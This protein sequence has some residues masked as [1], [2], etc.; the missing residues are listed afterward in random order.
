[1]VAP[2]S[3]TTLA[4]EASTGALQVLVVDD[5]PVA[6]GLL[7]DMA[8]ACGW[9]VETSPSG[10][11]ALA[12]HRARNLAGEPPFQVLLMDWEM[13]ELDGWDTIAC[14]RELDPT[15]K[16]P[17]TVMVTAHGRDKL[18]QRSSRDQTSLHAFLVKP[19]TAY[20]LS[21]AVSKAQLGQSNVRARPRAMHVDGAR[22]RGLR[23]LLVEDN[24][25]NQ[26]VALELLEGEGAT[27]A[28]ADNGQLG[29]D[30]V[31]D[32][33]PPY[34]AVLM[35]VQMPV[36]DGYTATHVIREDL[37]LVSLPIIAMTANAMAS[38]REACLAAG[39]TDHIG[40]PFDLPYLIQVLRKHTGLD[41][42]ELG[43]STIVSPTKEPLPS[44]DAL[45][46]AGAVARMGGNL[47]LYLRSVQPYIADLTRLPDQLDACLQAGNMTDATRL[48]HTL[49]GLSATVGA[50]AMAMVAATGEKLIQSNGTPDD[51]SAFG[52]AFRTAVNE[53]STELTDMVQQLSARTQDVQASSTPVNGNAL[54]MLT[55]LQALSERL[56]VLDMDAMVLYAE[57]RQKY[58]TAN[59]AGFDALDYAMSDM[60]FDTALTEA[61]TLL[62]SLR[63]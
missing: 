42:I 50:K 46:V 10:T 27:V 15:A 40:K 33:N 11:H 54:A 30:A 9:S 1:V 18:S 36:M 4:S 2:G 55:D 3:S 32:A 63:G 60:D 26:Q 35:D 57:L 12:L 45:D 21:D 24:P 61:D 51:L 56:R 6:R 52:T 23:L 29:V 17:I 41:Q 16:P 38:D 43:L 62:Q 22:L 25:I 28:L 5:N 13:P 37:G 19:V 8:R 53:A 7:A 47:D 59:E 58:P 31:R 39:M 44:T 14:L 48:L 34:D 49:K 20:M